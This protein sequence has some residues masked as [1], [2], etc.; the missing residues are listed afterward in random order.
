MTAVDKPAIGVSR[1][2]T[3]LFSGRSRECARATVLKLQISHS[4]PAAQLTTRALYCGFRPTADWKISSL[5]SW[6]IPLGES[7]G[8]SGLR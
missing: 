3:E 5:V 1:K 7:L 6:T 4:A 2:L 8:A